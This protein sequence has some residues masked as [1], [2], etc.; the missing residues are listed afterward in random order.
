MKDQLI[1]KKIFGIYIAIGRFFGNCFA[2]AIVL[3]WHGAV[4]PSSSHSPLSEERLSHLSPRAAQGVRERHAKRLA[5]P[6][7]FNYPAWATLTL[8]TVRGHLETTLYWRG[9]F[10][11]DGNSEHLAYHFGT[12]HETDFGG[13][14]QYKGILG[15]HTNM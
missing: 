5:E 12:H 11:L 10:R 4:K 15:T 1:Y 14:E 6:E 8:R 2:P 13:Y 9:W 3:E 7:V